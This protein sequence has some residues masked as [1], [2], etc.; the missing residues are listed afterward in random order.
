MTPNS[1]ISLLFLFFMV[2]ANASDHRWQEVQLKKSNIFQK[3][4]DCM[5]S[6]PHLD[7]VAPLLA[8]ISNTMQHSIPLKWLTSSVS[9][10]LLNTAF[11]QDSL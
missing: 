10:R 5:P 1:V 3:A 9:Q 4:L 7:A 11:V 2:L 6:K 8:C